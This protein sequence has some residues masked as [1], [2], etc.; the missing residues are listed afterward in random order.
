[1]DFATRV[2]AYEFPNDKFVVIGSGL[3]DQLGLRRSS[4]VDLVVAA[5]LFAD[6]ASSG[7][8]V[9]GTKG[10]DSSLTRG[11]LDVWDGYD[12]Y[13]FAALYE[14]GQEI[15]GVRFIATDMLINKK[16]QRGDK[17]DLADIRLLEDYYAAG[18]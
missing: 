9:S 12:E 10:R 3:L 6:L 4:D 2:K 18:R 17:K 11:E 8:Y 13:S 7:K 1:M 14:A 5:D 16:R 15:E